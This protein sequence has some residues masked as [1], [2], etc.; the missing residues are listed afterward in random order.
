M[1]TLLV[2]YYWCIKTLISLSYHYWYVM[3]L[4]SELTEKDYKLR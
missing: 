3:Y 4:H 2:I 1:L